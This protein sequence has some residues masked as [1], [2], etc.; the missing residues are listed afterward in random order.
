MPKRT[1]N[2]VVS[3]L[4]RSVGGM[5]LMPPISF[6]LEPGHIAFFRGKSGTGKS[7][8]QRVIAGLDPPDTPDSVILEGQSPF[9]TTLPVWRTRVML[10]SQSRVTLN[11]SPIALFERAL[12]LDVR[13]RNATPSKTVSDFVEAASALGLSETTLGKDWRV[14]S[15]GENQRA[16]LALALALQPPCLLLDEVTSALD[17]EAVEQ[18]ENAI[19]RILALGTSV[20]MVTHDPDQPGRLEARLPAEHAHFV[21]FA[22]PNT[23]ILA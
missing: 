16:A 2:L 14:L 4:C 15:G 20:V 17:V 6:E 9:E 11:G 1:G 19:V 12:T 3:N 18:V 7:T 8:A 13:K 5:P 21:C 22:N 23:E 10:V